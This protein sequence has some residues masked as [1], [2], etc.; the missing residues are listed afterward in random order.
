MIFNLQETWGGDM[1]WW[2]WAVLLVVVLAALGGLAWLN[3]GRRRPA[4][5]PNDHRESGWQQ[6]PS[7]GSGF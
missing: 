1:Y 4:R 5:D 3:S 2:V 7:A 6:P